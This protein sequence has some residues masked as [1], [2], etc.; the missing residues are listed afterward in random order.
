MVSSCVI[1]YC[2]K[3]ASTVLYCIQEDTQTMKQQKQK[4]MEHA[5]NH[6]IWP[7]P[8]KLATILTINDNIGIYFAYRFSKTTIYVNMQLSIY[9]KKNW[10]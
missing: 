5:S 2:A 3:P 1:G 9:V 6:N 4:T 10:I 8:K 7:F